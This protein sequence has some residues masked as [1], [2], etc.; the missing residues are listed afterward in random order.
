MSKLQIFF[1]GKPAR[2][3]GQIAKEYLMSLNVNINFKNCKRKNHSLLYESKKEMF[4][5]N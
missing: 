1:L 3:G 2:N 5:W 4:K